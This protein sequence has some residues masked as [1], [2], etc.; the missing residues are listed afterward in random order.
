MIENKK[1]KIT[2]YNKKGP[3]SL[4]KKHEMFEVVFEDDDYYIGK[5]KKRDYTLLIKKEDAMVL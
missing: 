1:I 4:Y 2:K 3:F 5:T